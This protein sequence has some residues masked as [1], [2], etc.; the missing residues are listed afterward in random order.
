MITI[1]TDP[2]TSLEDYLAVRASLMRL[3]DPSA[4]GR[5]R[6]MGFGRAWPG[7]A[8]LAAFAYRIPVR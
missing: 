6:V 3:L 7:D 4:M 8:S 5:F 1:Q 2:G